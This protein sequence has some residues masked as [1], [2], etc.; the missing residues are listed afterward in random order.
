MQVVVHLSFVC[1]EGVGGV[2]VVLVY[3]FIVFLLLFL[4]VCF[5][6]LGGGWGVGVIQEGVYMSVRLI[7]ICRD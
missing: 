3:L 1:H 6:F 2:V 7:V 5:F 4:C